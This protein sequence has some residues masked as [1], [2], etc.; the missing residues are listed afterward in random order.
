VFA[1]KID[2]V[3]QA[4]VATNSQSFKALKLQ[5]LPVR[6]VCSDTMS[7]PDQQVK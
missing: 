4:G 7:M 3:E 5:T 6:C 1:K 2:V